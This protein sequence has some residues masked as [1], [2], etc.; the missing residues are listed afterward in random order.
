MPNHDDERPE[1]RETVDAG[2]RGF[3]KSVGF[4]GAGAAAAMSVAALGDAESREAPEEQIKGRYAL[5]PHV[6][7]FYFLNR[8]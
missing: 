8:L 2:R 1:N 6:E 3:L 5:N 7:R 4:A